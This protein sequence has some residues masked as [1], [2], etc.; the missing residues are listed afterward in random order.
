MSL[1]PDLYSLTKKRIMED[2]G[3]DNNAMNYQTKSR[4]SLFSLCFPQST[5]ARTIWGQFS[6]QNKTL[7]VGTYGR[8]Y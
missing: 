4:N 7:V 3:Y 6:H 5:L 1:L 8:I 2:L